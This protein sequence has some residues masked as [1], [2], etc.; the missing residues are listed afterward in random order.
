MITGILRVPGFMETSWNLHLSCS[1]R[2]CPRAEV[3]LEISLANL[4]L[5]RAKSN[6]SNSEVVQSLQQNHSVSIF[7]LVSFPNFPN[8]CIWKL[9]DTFL[10]IHWIGKVNEQ[11]E[12]DSYN[13]Q[14][15]DPIF[16]QTQTCPH[17]S[18]YHWWVR[19]IEHQAPAGKWPVASCKLAESGASRDADRMG[20]KW[21]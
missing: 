18:R 5:S 6:I 19:P 3:G 17:V 4:Q 11:Y 20:S 2:I 9:G 7:V 10:N 12:H 15:L 16:R 14:I 1:H 13:H 8:G 21:F